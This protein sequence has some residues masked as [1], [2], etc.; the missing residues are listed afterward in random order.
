[1]TNTD[2]QPRGSECWCCGMTQPSDQLVA[3]GNHPEVHLCIRCAYSVRNWAREIEDR[4]KTG[5]GVRARA[6]ARRVRQSVVRHHLHQ[7]RFL[8]RPLR[9]LG[10]RLP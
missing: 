3:L 2:E 10:R 7:S 5:I 4:D 6:A 8:G 9:W 1:M